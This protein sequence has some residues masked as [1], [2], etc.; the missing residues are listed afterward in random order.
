MDN[1]KDW[2]SCTGYNYKYKECPKQFNPDFYLCKE[3]L[4]YALQALEAAELIRRY[5]GKY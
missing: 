5:N 1:E 4:E 3:C 2:C